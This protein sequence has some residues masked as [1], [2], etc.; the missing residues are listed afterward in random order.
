[1]KSECQEILPYGSYDRESP[2]PLF[3][4]FDQLFLPV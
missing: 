3:E 2:E 1:M 4:V